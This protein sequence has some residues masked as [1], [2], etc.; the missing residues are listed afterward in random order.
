MPCTR[1]CSLCHLHNEYT[2]ALR[3]ARWQ[4]R[5]GTMLYFLPCTTKAAHWGSAQN[6][7]NCVSGPWIAFLCRNTTTNTLSDVLT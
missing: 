6:R 3:V 7:I 1:A 5:T 4:L 2:T